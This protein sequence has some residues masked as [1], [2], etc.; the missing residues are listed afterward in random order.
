MRGDQPGRESRPCGVD[1]RR[2][3]S[4]TTST[5]IARVLA[6]ALALAVL[7]GVAA[8]TTEV[9]ADRDTSGDRASV[10]AGSD[11]DADA[12]YAGG[13][14]TTSE[15]PSETVS[16]PAPVTTEVPV[17]GGGDIE[18]TVAAV[19]Q[20]VQPAVA[21]DQPGDFGSGVAVSLD[22][23]EKI[24][25]TSDLPGEIAG[26]GVAMTFTI[27][28][29]GD[30]AIDL[31]AVVVDVVDSNGVSAIGMTASPAAPFGGELPAGQQATGVYVVTFPQNFADPA[32]ISV[33]YSA[34]A[35]VVTFTGTL[36]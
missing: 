11:P 3:P 17:P 16:V 10:S 5:G 22:S 30:A 13:L 6:A 8:C 7:F 21:L 29:D 1:G 9:K 23:V 14:A 26:P 19:E 24:T 4:A 15:T 27:R 32:T 31:S 28:N 34:Q 2:R 12:T 33:T 25:T 35:P 18:H 20:P 36:A